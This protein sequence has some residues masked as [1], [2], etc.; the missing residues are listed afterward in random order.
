MQGNLYLRVNIKNLL[1]MQGN[2]S[3]VSYT[4]HSFI[5]IGVPI[6]SKANKLCLY[7]EKCVEDKWAMKL[8]AGIFPFP[9]PKQSRLS[10]S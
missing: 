4:C 10:S 9:I 8:L 7:H 6:F 2:L 3:L 5:R 1:W